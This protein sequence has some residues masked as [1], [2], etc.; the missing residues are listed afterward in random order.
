MKIN[1]RFA[2]LIILLG[3]ITF[4]N[5]AY[6]V[7]FKKDYRSKEIKYQYNVSKQDL[8]YQKDK[9]LINRVPTGYMTVDEYEKASEYRDKTK[10]EFEIPKIETP[11]D[12]KYIPKP[13]YKIVKYNDPPGNS[14]LSLGKK[15]F[16]NRQINAQGIVSPDYTRL[17]YPAVYYYNDS[18]SVAADLFEVPL[19]GDDNNLSK[20]L[21]ANVA[22]R[23][24]EPI[25]STIKA[26]D[27][28]AA[29]RSLTPVDFSTDGTKL[30]AKEKIGSSEDGIWETR[31]F[32]YDFLNKTSYDL[33]SL[34]ESIK[35]YWK[36]K[37][38][39]LVAKRWDIYPLGFDSNDVN[40]IVV[41]AY[42]YTGEVPVYLGAWSINSKGENPI[43]LSMN[44]DFKPSVSSNGYKVVQ[45]GVETY[46]SSKMAEKLNKIEDKV[47]KKERKLVDKKVVKQIGQDYKYELKELRADYKDQYRD[48]K[49]LQTFKGSTE[50]TE[51]EEAYNNYQQNQ[52]QK[53]IKK[54]EKH[55]E[56]TQKKI[57]K[58]DTK[59]QKLTD[60]TQ[61]IIDTKLEQQDNNIQK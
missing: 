34:R 52:L 38:L 12:F 43:M 44:K 5:K 23:N 24:P 40:R 50:G 41:Q 45:H 55:I 22:K 27:N 37:G 36:S 33:N 19:E 1:K 49:K 15:L 39:N 46:Q 59:I 16:I 56:K 6:C 47:I 42:A 25:L 35:Y 14:E 21:K 58:L 7:S 10:L 2:I 29:F 13:T 4:C 54:A 11:S 53:D 48:N 18:G 32:I 17:V 9:K 8:Q 26:I 31:I 3:L 60:K 51:L 30:L 20:I 57:D 28:Y 61:E